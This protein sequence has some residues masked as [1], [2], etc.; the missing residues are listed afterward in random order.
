MTLA[1]APPLLFSDPI[2]LEHQTGSHPECPARLSTAT[3]YLQNRP[4][5]LKFVRRDS[6]AA[7]MEQLERVHTRQ[8]IRTVEY[9]AD[10]QGGGRVEADTVMSPRSYEVACRAAGAAIAAVDGVL[11]TPHRQALCLTRPPGHHALSDAI[12]GFCLFNNVAVAAAHAIS[13]YGLDRVLIV[14][15]DVHHGNGTQDIFYENEQVGFLSVHRYP[16]YPGTGAADE[17]GSGPGLG[18]KFNLPLAF[19]VRRREYLTQFSSLLETAARRCQP[20]LILISA[21]FDAHAR[22]PIGSLGLE[23]E[24][25]TTLTQIVGEIAQEYCEGRLVSLLEGGYDLTALTESLECHMEALA[26]LAEPLG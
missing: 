16:F 9:I 5:W 13:A 12:M 6:A 24:D 23:S 22:D 26:V 21:G 25:F 15:W 11:T 18:T 2:Y 8:H 19:G 4:V 7:T 14:D 20:D 1:H 10:A 3:A 17:T